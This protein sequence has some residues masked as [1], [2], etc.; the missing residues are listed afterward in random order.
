M[1]AEHPKQT[2]ELKICH[3]RE[4]WYLYHFFRDQLCNLRSLFV[5]SDAL[6]YKDEQLNV[7]GYFFRV[8]VNEDQTSVLYH[9]LRKVIRRIPR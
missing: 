9:Y 4:V 6:I 7:F 8:L 5:I 3:F 2:L 1:S